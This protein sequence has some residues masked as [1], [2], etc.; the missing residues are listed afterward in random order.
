L[1][2]FSLAVVIALMASDAFAQRSASASAPAAQPRG[3][4]S[5]DTS[6]ATA[7]GNEVNVSVGGYTYKEPGDLS[8]S[9]HGPKIGGEYTATLSLGKSQRWFT[10]IDGRGTFGNVT[11]DGWCSP[12]L[13][14]PDSTSPNG[15]ALDLGDASPCSESGDRDWY[16]ETRGL[17]GRDFIAH[18]WGMSPETGL[19]VRHLSNGTNGVPGHRTDTYLYVPFGLTARTRVASHGVLSFNVEYDRLL[20]GWQ[21]TRDSELGGGDVPA[22]PTA[23]AF[24]IE[25]FTD[26]SFAQHGGWALRT[27]AKYQVTRHWSVEP[28]YIYWS[29]DASPVNDQTATFTVNNVTVQ[30]QFGAY[31]PV[32]VTHEFVVKLGFHF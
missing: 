24:T 15:W 6:L 17:V 26:I 8:I 22:T 23:P 12:F 7:P 3:A 2:T 29:V 18:Q 10:Q 30:E 20:H 16:L 31:E 19:G 9:I 21:T 1:K 14:T 13:I 4:V 5:A 32:N 28:A 25:G 11:Y 27:S